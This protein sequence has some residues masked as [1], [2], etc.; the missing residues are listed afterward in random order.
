MLAN[1]PSEF[2]PR[3][4]AGVAKDYIKKY[5]KEKIVNVFG[6]EGAYK[7]GVEVK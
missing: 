2:D 3:K 1:K 4:Y 7:K 6:S 5:Y